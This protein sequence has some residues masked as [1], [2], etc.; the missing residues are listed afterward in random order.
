MPRRRR[1]SAEDFDL[2]FVESD[3]TGTK[4]LLTKSEYSRSKQRYKKLK[5]KEKGKITRLKKQE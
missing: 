4:L 3:L 1:K 5:P 2:Y